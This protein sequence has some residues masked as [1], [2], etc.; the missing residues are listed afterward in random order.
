MLVHLGLALIARRI[1]FPLML[2]MKV[3]LVNMMFLK[4]D[5]IRVAKAHLFLFCV[6]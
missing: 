3:V 5:S 4:F 6:D 2:G 1:D